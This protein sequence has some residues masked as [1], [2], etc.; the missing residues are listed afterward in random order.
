MSFYFKIYQNGSEKIAAICDEEI[1]GK[2]FTHNGVRINVKREFYGK[3]LFEKDEILLELTSCTSINAFGE[4]VCSILV[5]SNIA[6]PK[7]I[8][9]ISDG[10]NK[11]GHVIV[12][13]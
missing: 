2:S 12:I 7:S 3:E 1:S 13:K 6:H 5:E 8:L 11:I 4:R 9:W 10:D